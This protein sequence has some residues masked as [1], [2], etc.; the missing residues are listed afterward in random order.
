MNP[1]KMDIDAKFGDLLISFNRQTILEIVA[2]TLV[3]LPK[4]DFSWDSGEVKVKE[5]EEKPLEQK[6]QE[7]QQQ[8]SRSTIIK[9]SVNSCGFY[10]NRGT[11]TL[12][13]FG[14]NGLAFMMDDEEISMDVDNATSVFEHSGKYHEFVRCPEDTAKFLY[15][16][17][18]KNQYVDKPFITVEMKNMEVIYVHAMTNSLL[19]YLEDSQFFIDQMQKLTAATKETTVKTAKEAQ[20]SI[21]P[22]VDIKV[23]NIHL[24]I[25]ERPYYF[26]TAIDLTLDKLH[27]SIKNPDDKNIQLIA[28]KGGFSIDRGNVTQQVLPL[29]TFDIDFGKSIYGDKILL[30]VC[31]SEMNFFM[32]DILYDQLLTT[33][34]DNFKDNYLQEFKE[35]EEI[36]NTINNALKKSDETFISKETQEAKEVQILDTKVDQTPQTQD[37]TQPQT[38]VQIVANVKLNTISLTLASIEKKQDIG[39]FIFAGLTL[40]FSK[41]DSDMTLSCDIREISIVD[42]RSDLFVNPNIISKKSMINSNNDADEND[43][44]PIAV[45][46]DMILIRCYIQE[47]ETAVQ[48]SLNSISILPNATFID[49]ILSFV[50]LPLKRH[51]RDDEIDSSFDIDIAS[52]VA[53]LDDNMLTLTRPEI[54]QEK[55]EIETAQKEKINAPAPP[56][57]IY[58]TD[59]KLSISVVEIILIE[60][61]KNPESRCIGA[62]LSSYVHFEQQNNVKEVNVGFN[63]VDVITFNLHEINETSAVVTDISQWNVSFIETI[64]NDQKLRQIRVNLPK[65]VFR[66]SYQDC[67]ML[68]G[69]SLD[70]IDSL[71]EHLSSTMD[72]MSQKSKSIDRTTDFELSSVNTDVVPAETQDDTRLELEVIGDVV[73][74]VLIL[75]LP[76][77]PPM[78]LI[79]INMS[80]I[81]TLILMAKQ[82]IDI[83]A[84]I[85][86]EFNIWSDDQTIYEPFI[87]EFVYGCHILKDSKQTNVT[88]GPITQDFPFK[89]DVAF[90]PPSADLNINLVSNQFNMLLNS[91]VQLK[92]TETAKTT[93]QDLTPVV[94]LNRS[95]YDFTLQFN[96]PHQTTLQSIDFPS[97]TMNDVIFEMETTKQGIVPF[98][99]HAADSHILVERLRLVGASLNTP[100]SFFLTRAYSTILSLSDGTNLLLELRPINRMRTLVISSAVRIKNC[101]DFDVEIES[102]LFRDLLHSG[103]ISSL[104]LVG[105]EVIPWHLIYNGCQSPDYM[106]DQKILSVCLDKNDRNL[107]GP[108]P[109]NFTVSIETSHDEFGP[110]LLIKPLISIRNTLPLNVEIVLN[111]ESINLEANSAKVDILGT[112]QQIHTIE[113]CIP[114]LNMKSGILSV[115]DLNESSRVVDMFI[116]G[117]A[118]EVQMQIMLEKNE[119]SYSIHVSH[120]VANYLPI[121][122]ELEVDSHVYLLN[123][124]DQE[125]GILLLTATKADENIFK[126]RT[127][128]DIDIDECTFIPDIRND[129]HI[130]VGDYNIGVDIH[131]IEGNH[132][133]VSLL[134]RFHFINKSCNSFSIEPRG[135]NSVEIEAGSTHE[136]IHFS[137]MPLDEKSEFEVKLA[138]SSGMFYPTTPINL[139]KVGDFFLATEF[140]QKSTNL[141]NLFIQIR[142]QDSQIVCIINDGN[143]LATPFKITNHSA[144]ILHICQVLSTDGELVTKDSTNIK[145]TPLTA[146]DSNQNSYFLPQ[147]Q[148][149]SPQLR[150]MTPR[151]I[152]PEFV[153][154]DL[155]EINIIPKFIKVSSERQLMYRS[156][157]R[158]GTFIVAIYDFSEELSKRIAKKELKKQFLEMKVDISIPNITVVLIDTLP[159]ELALFNINQITLNYEKHTSSNRIEFKIHN[160]QLENL[161]H[162]SMEPF[163]MFRPRK[164]RTMQLPLMRLTVVQ[165]IEDKH[166]LFLDYFALSLQEIELRMT[167][168]FL[169]TCLNFFNVLELDRISKVVDILTD[170]LPARE[171]K[172]QLSLIEKYM[173]MELEKQVN[174]IYLNN[175]IIHPLCFIVTFECTDISL[176]SFG[177]PRSVIRLFSMLLNVKDFKLCMNACSFE[178]LSLAKD[179][180]VSTMVDF[181]RGQ[182]IGP[183]TAVK[184]LLSFS[185]IGNPITLFNSIGNGVDDFYYEPEDGEVLDLGDIA[186]RTAGGMVSLFRNTT[187]GAFG[188]IGGFMG[189]LE[190]G[191]VNISMDD[192]FA[193]EHAMQRQRTEDLGSG[194]VEAG[195][196][197]VGGFWDGI[198]GIVTQPIK[199]AEEEGFIGGIKGFG[200]GIIGVVAKPLAG[201]TAGIARIADGAQKSFSTM[202]KVTRSR[203]ERALAPFKPIYAYNSIEAIVYHKIKEEEENSVWFHMFIVDPNI[204]VLTLTHLFCYTINTGKLSLTWKCSLQSIG[205]DRIFLENSTII[206]VTDQSSE[207]FFGLFSEPIQHKITNIPSL[208]Y[209]HDIVRWIVSAKRAKNDFDSEMKKKKN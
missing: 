62:I 206:I 113:I 157:F 90:T 67:L 141:L 51:S 111:E 197:F 116:D 167:D 156:Y 125:P 79:R 195:K 194:L 190:K 199:G 2:L 149:H 3:D 193:Q 179:A 115:A 150:L 86:F 25:P 169:V 180:F 35:E 162:G 174:K 95:D 41:E 148:A 134:P 93:Q 124:F 17:M 106:V 9:T 170:F 122:F 152:D 105:G 126:L 20:K 53:D 10:I 173:Q 198:T 38:S 184:G 42:L 119:S 191:L 178:K 81:S 123:A 144:H 37:E 207:G 186:S 110:I 66:F 84:T 99:H 21:I 12:F 171:K 29:T 72:E 63:I 203:F 78:P 40:S 132:F 45:D 185:L 44:Y 91:L 8:P 39:S 82:S 165:N 97:H 164:E 77:K 151:L 181:Y 57:S 36:D 30:D 133:N 50:L 166:T 54:K 161:I 108:T 183:L 121:P 69:I 103:D 154:I 24:I 13:K 102:N 159:R 46:N 128:D 4:I 175:F 59:I 177:I 129:Q 172:V 32:D 96:P 127:I 208:E 107:I 47:D 73:E 118:V 155:N 28:L 101:I 135:G 94:L 112:D 1:E 26:D 176:A 92:T 104:P 202:N 27:L 22:T 43:E 188:V 153:I 15:F 64:E 19:A 187:S 71:T 146:L 131:N 14:L 140:R 168:N 109:N 48:L 136:V 60:E 11:T 117:S 120:V 75:D 55:V 33:L 209:S 16:K 23:N 163:V 83:K 18:L 85:G 160:I 34:N 68:Y 80:H 98:R 7:Q 139:C 31:T 200:A 204:Y 89:N 88:L 76:N 58:R 192:Q 65:I 49:D 6:E 205:T 182:V 114:K 100:V 74:F 196:S 142:L 70:Y 130:K 137:S 138:E 145:T 56:D 143:S 201:T 52:D 5:I 87:E 147:F 61:A 158:N 189:T